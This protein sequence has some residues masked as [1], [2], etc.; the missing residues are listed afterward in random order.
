ML[1]KVIVLL[2]TVVIFVPVPAKADSWINRNPWTL[3]TPVVASPSYTSG[4]YKGVVFQGDDQELGSYI[5]YWRLKIHLFAEGREKVSESFVGVG[6]LWAVCHLTAYDE[7]YNKVTCVAVNSQGRA[8]DPNI[9][10][11]D[12]RTNVYNNFIAGENASR[13]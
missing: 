12:Y 8:L 10:R 2:T 11:Q 9:Y 5:Q 7:N 13:D 1:K 6:R 3:Q 4:Y